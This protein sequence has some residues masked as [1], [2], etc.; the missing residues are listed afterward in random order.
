V[1]P[2]VPCS[3]RAMAWGRSA[4]IRRIFFDG[5]AAPLQLIGAGAAFADTGRLAMNPEEADRAA[6]LWPAVFNLIRLVG[7][8]VKS[9]VGP[10]GVSAVAPE[11]A[12]GGFGISDEQ[13]C[14][15]AVGAGACPFFQ[16]HQ[17]HQLLSG[18]GHGHLLAFLS[19]G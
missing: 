13:P 10:E 16:L 17:L 4:G 6:A 2:G 11:L 8:P 7:S 14:F 12:L 15:C 1:T 19:Q 3:L 5:L 18:G 9:E